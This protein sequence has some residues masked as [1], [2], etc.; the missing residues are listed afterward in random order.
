[1]LARPLGSPQ[2]PPLTSL[3]PH[4]ERPGNGVARWGL[5][6]WILVVCPGHMMAA[7]NRSIS[8]AELGME[9][10]RL[11][12]SE[13]EVAACEN[14]GLSTSHPSTSCTLGAQLWRT[15]QTMMPICCYSHS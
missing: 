11:G 4:T 3:V 15:V 8:S 6:I 10:L 7:V 13:N 14:T 12:G 1:M 2:R 5:Q 9:E